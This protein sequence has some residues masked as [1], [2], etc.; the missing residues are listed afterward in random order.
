MNYR[1]LLTE[2]VK[3]LENKSKQTGVPYGIL[4]KVY[5]RGMAAWTGGHRPGIGQHQWAFARVN[6][7]LTG[8]KTQKT[9]DKDLWAKV[10]AGAKKGIKGKLKKKPKKESMHESYDHMNEGLD[11]LAAIAKALI[12]AVTD[13][14]ILSSRLGLGKTPKP[15]AGDIGNKVRKSIRKGKLPGTTDVVD[16]N[17]DVPLDDLVD[18]LKKQ[19][20]DADDIDIDTPMG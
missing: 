6:S 3:G 19:I 17:L 4:K 10:P 1:F 7:F 2:K 11:D 20:D 15:K 12:K 5:D 8:G 14:N 18:R 13:E 16:D 9:A